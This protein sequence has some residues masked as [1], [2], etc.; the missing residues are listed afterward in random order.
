MIFHH[1]GENVDN[2]FLQHHFQKKFIVFDFEIITLE[3]HSGAVKKGLI[4]NKSN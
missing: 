3:R 4:L 2:L 1:F